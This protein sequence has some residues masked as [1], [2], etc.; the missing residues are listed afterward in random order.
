MYRLFI[1]EEYDASL[2]RISKRDREL[3]EKKTEV[4]VFP[5]LKEEPHFGLNIKKLK[6][7]VP[8]TWR[9]RIGKFRLFYIICEKELIVKLLAAEHRKDAY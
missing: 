1:T 2:E 5:Q 9:Y 8:E 6:G 4:Y 7:Y 3:I